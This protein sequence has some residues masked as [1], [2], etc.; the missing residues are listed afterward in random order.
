MIRTNAKAF[1]LVEMMVTTVIVIAVIGSL[2]SLLSSGRMSWGAYENKIA[3][4]RDT[5]QTLAWLTRDLREASGVSVTQDANSATI[6]F[7]KSDVGSVSYAWANSGADANRILRTFQA[8][9]AIIASNISA[10]SFTTTANSVVVDVTAS[11][12]D[13]TGRTASIQLIEKIAL[14]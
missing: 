5:R 11:K 4:Q 9:T 2:H 14:R 3:V 6:S 1:S 7:S 10:L 12:T 8:A 13:S